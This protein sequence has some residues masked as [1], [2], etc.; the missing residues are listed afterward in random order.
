MESTVVRR[1]AMLTALRMDF[2]VITDGLSPSTIVACA[3]PLL[4]SLCAF[5][6][7]PLAAV[8]M[9]AYLT[10]GYWAL[11]ISGFFVLS[12]NRPSN[13]ISAV[14]P[15]SRRTQVRARYLAALIVLVYAVVQLGVELAIASLAFGLDLTGLGATLPSVLMLFVLLVAVQMPVFYSTD[16]T[17]AIN[18]LVI[19]TTAVFLMATLVKIVMP[20]RVAAALAAALAAVPGALWAVGGV[21]IGIIALGVSYRISLHVW[22]AKEL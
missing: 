9:M 17:Q 18:R 16:F 15:V 10:V 13:T 19:G 11:S 12:S 3:L 4:L 20:D 7:S 2:A 1:R 8:M 6:P 22:T 14:M 21:A 5:I